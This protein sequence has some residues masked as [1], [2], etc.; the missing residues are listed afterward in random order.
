[1]YY[2]SIKKLVKEIQECHSKYLY[3]VDMEEI[4]SKK[5]LFLIRSA[6]E[7]VLLKFLDMLTER[8]YEGI[9]NLIGRNE[10]EEYI[11]KYKQLDI[12]LCTV[13][14]EQ[15]YSV[16]N[17]KSYIDNV[18]AD[19]ICFL[20]QK[21]ISERHINLLEISSYAKCDSYAVSNLL[22]VSAFRN[23]ER[24][25]IGRRLYEEL[26]NWIFLQT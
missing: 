18:D 8:N 12:R 22:H 7:E 20:Y 26:C 17:T 13:P 15:R 5:K 10:D 16:E 2:D 4:L 3:E 14:D 24:E 6:R 25:L 21:E 11:G 19:G 1:M 9:I 23:L